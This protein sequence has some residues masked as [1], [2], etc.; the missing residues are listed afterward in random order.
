MA[1]VTGD[2][3]VEV[4]KRGSRVLKFQPRTGSII[5]SRGEVWFQPDGFIEGADGESMFTG[6]ALCCAEREPGFGPR[7]PNSGG[8]LQGIDGGGVLSEGGLTESAA[9]VCFGDSCIECKS[10]SVGA[11]SVCVFAAA[12]LGG[13]RTDE[14][15][16]LTFLI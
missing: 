3:G 16:S 11:D 2:N 5:Q 8:R 4:G 10:L 1:G 9:V 6:G 13:S 15:F 12:S 7:G 14:L